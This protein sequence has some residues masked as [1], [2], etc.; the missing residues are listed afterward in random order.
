MVKIYKTKREKQGLLKGYLEYKKAVEVLK[1][2][3]KIGVFWDAKI[4]DDG[5]WGPKVKIEG[6]WFSEDNKELTE[7]I[8]ELANRNVEF[9]CFFS[10]RNGNKTAHINC[11]V[12]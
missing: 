7:A 2:V 6:K 10:N 4:E 1:K 8:T 3:Q 5:K 9:S 12:K 11:D